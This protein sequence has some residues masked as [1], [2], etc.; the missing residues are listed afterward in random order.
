MS[1]TSGTARSIGFFRRWIRE[2]IVAVVVTLIV[3][4]LAAV[5]PTL[6]ALTFP[7]YVSGNYLIIGPEERPGTGPDVIFAQLKSYDGR[8]W[9]SMLQG[10]QRWSVAGYWKNNYLIFAYRSDGNGPSSIGFG[11]Q[12]F[13]PVQAGEESIL[14]GDV[15]G[16]FCLEDAVDQKPQI[17]RCPNV[18]VRAEPE[19]ASKW[20]NKYAAYLGTLKQQC[21]PVDIPM[22][23]AAA[24]AE[25]KCPTKH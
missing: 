9:G 11:E 12:F 3:A 1:E 5:W 23:M 20:T 8:V 6:Q 4:A 14:V 13:T 15:R 19:A 21:Q 18:L 25:I 2:I 16:N 22:A 7:D 24:K 17:L 10:S